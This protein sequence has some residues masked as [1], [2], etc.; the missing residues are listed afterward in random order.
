MVSGQHWAGDRLILDVRI[1]P[2]AS[3]N[4]V[5]GFQDDGRLKIRLTSPPVD[6]QANRQLIQYL[7]KIFAV[8]RGSITLLSGH[9]SRNKRLAITTP[10]QLPDFIRKPI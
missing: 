5:V 10:G 8:S 9:K 1:Q 7:A 4:E 3:R 6:D 2:R